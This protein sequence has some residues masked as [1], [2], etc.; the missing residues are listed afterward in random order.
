MALWDTGASCFV[1]S[2]RLVSGSEEVVK[3]DRT[4]IIHDYAGRAGLGGQLYTK[5]LSFFMAGKKFKEPME[6]APLHERLGYDI[7]IPNW[8]IEES[9]LIL[10]CQNGVYEVSYPGTTEPPLRQ[11]PGPIRTGKTVDRRLRGEQDSTGSF[12]VEWDET[13]LIEDDEPI[14]CGFV[15]HADGAPKMTPD[16]QWH[17]TSVASFMVTPGLEHQ[18]TL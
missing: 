8:W 15:Y 17:K 2:D 5:P 11:T 4:T 12:T 7:I 1:V 18:G 14:Q 16:G 9:G 3:R 10:G 6:I 13:I